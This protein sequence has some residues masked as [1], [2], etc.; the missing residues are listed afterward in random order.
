MQASVHLD[1]ALIER[2]IVPDWVLP[3][4]P[5]DGVVGEGRHDPGVDLSQR[6]PP[7]G[8]G[9]DRHR[10]QRDVGVR[11]LLGRVRGQAEWAAQEVIVNVDHV[12]L[13]RHVLRLL[14]FS[15]KASKCFNSGDF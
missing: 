6:H 8:R 15:V 11:G 13:R 9:L 14:C 7:G 2:E 1:E 5:V 3:A 12:H 10:D 4:L